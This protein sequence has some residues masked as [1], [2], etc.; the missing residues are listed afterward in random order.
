MG[1]ILIFT[2]K[3]GVGKTS[4]AAAHARYSAVSGKKTLIVSTDMAHNLGDI[5]GMELGKT[6]FHI[7]ENLDVLE[8]DPNHMMEH[9]FADMKA[10]IFNMIDSSGL[11]LGDLAELNVFPGMDELF[12][13]LK[14]LEIYESDVYERI[15][16]DCAPTGETLSLLKFPELLGWYMEKFLPVGKVA[17]RVLSP[18]SKTVFKVELSNSAAISDIER[19]FLR[20]VEL[21]NLL[22]DREVTSIR[23]VAMPEKMV[24]EET[25]RNYM[26]MNLYDFNV[27]GLYINRILPREIQNDFFTEW[28]DIQ[29]TYIEELEAVFTGVAVYHIPWFEKDLNGIEGIDNI[30]KQVLVSKPV[31]DTVPKEHSERYEKTDFG[32]NLRLYLPCIDK[33]EIAM[34]ETATDLII[35]IGNFKRSIPKPNALR[36]YQ[37]NK[38]SF[39][40]Q[41]L[42]LSFET[43]KNGGN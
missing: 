9:E 10:A 28:L 19:L 20:L 18:I 36:N 27:D 16:V 14:I 17:L 43:M 22:K 23:L 37:V 12:S 5:F 32:Y 34:H 13:L 25:K 30:V 2:G 39:I 15:I 31:F 11:P 33:G 3:G 7:H 1:R 41:T 42:L 38:A 29:N 24:V 35:K 26:Y 8:I 6:V 21:Q 40:D 4:V